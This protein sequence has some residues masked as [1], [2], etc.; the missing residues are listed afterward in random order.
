MAIEITVRPSLPYVVVS[1]NPAQSQ[2]DLSNYATTSDLEN[3]SGVLANQIVS[4]AAGVSSINGAS[5]ILTIKG[6]GNVFVSTAGQTITVSGEGGTAQ[7]VNLSGYITTGQADVRYYSKNN[8]SGFL[9]SLSGLSV[10]YVVDVSG[11]LSLRLIVTGSILDGKINSLSGY[12]DGNFATTSYV[13]SISG[14]LYSQIQ[15]GGGSGVSHLNSLAG[16]INLI[17][18]TD[19]FLFNNT[20]NNINI[21]YKEQN[22]EIYRNASGQIT[23]V[24]YNADFSRLYRNNNN[25]ITG[26]FYNNY[27]KK[28]LYDVNDNVTGINVIYL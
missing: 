5:G 16:T 4:S 1:D 21:W 25:K 26:I 6:T 19:T 13:N 7:Y 18:S 28:I 27:F 3:A 20:G 24:R 17:S 15:A 23:G 12:L 2:P 8:E 11:A 14:A 10:Q 9:N 22:S